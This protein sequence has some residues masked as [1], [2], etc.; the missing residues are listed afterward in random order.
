MDRR[1]EPAERGKPTALLD[2]WSTS[3]TELTEDLNGTGSQTN[4]HRETPS[5]TR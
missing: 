4:H 1:V 3:L 5:L 2:R